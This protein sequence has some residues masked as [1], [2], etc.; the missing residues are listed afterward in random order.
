MKL[1][2]IAPDTFIN[3]A[4]VLS[5]T[6]FRGPAG[7]SSPMRTTV[8]AQVDGEVWYWNSPYAPTDVMAEIDLANGVPES[9]PNMVECARKAGKVLNEINDLAENKGL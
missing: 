4:M 1:A 6:P 3:P 2:K 7:H 8:R 5:V 9:V